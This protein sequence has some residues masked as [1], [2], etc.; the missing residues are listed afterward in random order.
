MQRN[1][2]AETTGNATLGYTAHCNF[3]FSFIHFGIRWDSLPTLRQRIQRCITVTNGGVGEK[4]S[5]QETSFPL[6]VAMK[7]AG[8]LA[9]LVL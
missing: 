7:V 4:R 8:Y 1:M 3:F 5:M 2:G 6:I 9:Q